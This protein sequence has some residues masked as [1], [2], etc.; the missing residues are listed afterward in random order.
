MIEFVTT[1]IKIYC[2]INQ[3]LLLL[4]GNILHQNVHQQ[5]EGRKKKKPS[6]YIVMDCQFIKIQLV[7]NF[8]WLSNCQN[9]SVTNFDGLVKKS[10]SVSECFDDHKFRHKF[11]HNNHFLSK[12][13]QISFK[14]IYQNLTIFLQYI[15][16]IAQY[17]IS[18]QSLI[19]N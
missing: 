18:L 5:C 19:C 11:R 1:S 15:I 6:K 8:D 3:E 10:I 17:H 14:K 4:T 2:T 12:Q 7:T 13:I 9:Q 16:T